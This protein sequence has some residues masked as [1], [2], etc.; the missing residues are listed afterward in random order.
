[1]IINPIIPIWLMSI[2]CI[3][4]M[5]TIILKRPLIDKKQNNEKTLREKKPIKNDIINICIKIAIIILLF[6]I[7]LRFMIPNGETTAISS[8]VNVLF[9]IDTS[10]S[11]R[12]LDYNGRKERFEAVINDC[13]YIVDELPGCKYSIITFGDT[14]KKLFPFISDTDMVQAE[15]KAITTEDDFYAKGTSINLV[16]EIFEKTL[17][18]EQKRQNGASKFVIFFITDGE[19]TKEGEKLESFA[20]IRQYVSNGAVMGYGTKSGGKMVSKINKDDPTSEFYYIDYYDEDYNRITAISKIDEENL[21]QIASDLEVDYIQMNKTSN[22]N[23]KLT[24]VRKQISNFQKTEDKISTYQD[25]YYI[26]MIP[27][28]VLLTIDFIVKKKRML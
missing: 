3:I 25:I 24:D 5:V 9:V 17:K 13:C 10:V 21:K 14:A 15:L 16:K 23:Y 18:E 1:M 7:N 12:A 22:I 27:L 20:N 26:F 6:V 8:D 2:I 28:V 4:L 19:I 11:M